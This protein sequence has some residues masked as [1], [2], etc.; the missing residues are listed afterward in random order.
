MYDAVIAGAGPVG[1]FLACELGLAGCSVLV[2][3]REPEPGSQWR[4]MPL[5]MR[6]L[7]AAS[8]EAFHRRGML[9]ALR[10]ASGVHDDPNE[11][12]DEEPDEGDSVRPRFVGH[13]AGIVL[14]PAEVDVGALPYRLP[15]PAL[16]GV[17]TSLA[18]VES[19]LSERAAELGVEIRRGVTVSAV[20]QDEDGVIVRD[21]EQ[22][23]AARWAVGCDGGRS[24]VRALAGFDFVGTE[25]QFTGYTMLVGIADPEKLSPGFT[26]TP[27]GM[28]IQMPTE[29]HVAMMDFDGG[30]FDRTQ[31]PSLEHLQS[32]LRRVSGTDVTLTDVHLV[33]TFTDRAMQ[34]TTYRRGRVLLAGDAAH[35]HSPLGGQGLNTG[36]GDA[37]NLG[38]KLAAVVRGQAPDTLLDTYIRERH[39]IGAWV[40]DWTRAQAAAMRPDKHGQAVQS[41]IRDLLETRDGTTYV[42][43]KVSGASLR[44]DLGG[45]HPLI[46][47]T[48]P[49][50]QLTDG[51]RLGEE[52]R[53]GRGVVLDFST[54]QRLRESVTG[55]ENR[56]RYVAGVA[57]DDLGLDAVVVRPDG[58]VVWAGE[59]EFDGKTFE[60]A[61]KLWYGDSES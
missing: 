22:E 39:P 18:A 57:K 16:H 51:T 10:A 24:A 25:P 20:E 55:R 14:D 9:S 3:E 41:V 49:D 36:I 35:I 53:D 27:T 23:Y 30:A 61:V 28:Y 42:Y 47:H 59:R 5:G 44:Y 19:V 38:W 60:R 29:G 12:P 7:S 1:L 17:M 54:D 46:G 43:G 56:L 26:L 6:G 4:S 52:M 58:I 11:G 32:V 40:L 48:A 21:G 13:F 37:M 2:L 15:S 34:T 8:V 33:S 31:R 50:F 45:E